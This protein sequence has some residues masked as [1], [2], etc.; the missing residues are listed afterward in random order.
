MM[1]NIQFNVNEKPLLTK[2]LFFE[3]HSM[4]PQNNDFNP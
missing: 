4:K 2:I 3:H 1:K